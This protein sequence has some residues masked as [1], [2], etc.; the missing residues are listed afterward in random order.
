MRGKSAA[1]GNSALMSDLGVDIGAL[2]AR[3][4]ALAGEGKTAMF[5]AIDGKAA[6]LIAVADPIKPTTASAIRAL[7]DSGLKII[8]ATGDNAPH[9]QGGRRKARHR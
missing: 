2:G 6:G 4:E 1:L 5:V 8:M 9:R 3:A 7:H